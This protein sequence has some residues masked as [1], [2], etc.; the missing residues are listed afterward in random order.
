MPYAT[1][2]VYVV[3]DHPLTRQDI[4]AICRYHYEGTSLD[5]TDGYAA[6][7]PHNARAHTN[8]MWMAFMRSL[9]LPVLVDGVTS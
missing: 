9:L 7:S 3:P 1:R 2:P 6:M 4:A 8:A 5:E